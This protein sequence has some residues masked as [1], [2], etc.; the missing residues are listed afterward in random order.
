MPLRMVLTCCHIITTCGFCPVTSQRKEANATY[1]ANQNKT[2][3]AN[4]AAKAMPN[5][6]SIKRV[7]N[8]MA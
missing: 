6:V 2:T 4:N 1:K 8:A 5:K 3:T 7:K